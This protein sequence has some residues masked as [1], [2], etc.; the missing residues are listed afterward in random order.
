[1]IAEFGEQLAW[2]SAAVSRHY[3]GPIAYRTPVIFRQSIHETVLCE[4]MIGFDIT[5]REEV[6]DSLTLEEVRWTK[7]LD[8]RFVV[9]SGFPILSRLTSPTGIEVSWGVLQEYVG[10]Y[11]LTI[12]DGRVF[13][14][15]TCKT[16]V[17]VSGHE[18]VHLW[19]NIT[20]G[21]KHCCLST[22]RLNIWEL[23][24]DLLALQQGRHILDPDDAAI[25][26]GKSATSGFDDDFHSSDSYTDLCLHQKDVGSTPDSSERVPQTLRTEDHSGTLRRVSNTPTMGN[27]DL[28]SFIDLTAEEGTPTEPSSHIDIADITNRSE[29]S[30]ESDFLSMSELSDETSIP[31][32]SE[33]DPIFDVVKGVAL[34]L[35]SLHSFQTRGKTTGGGDGFTSVTLT[36]TPGQAPLATGGQLPAKGKRKAEEE[37]ESEQ[38]RKRTRAGKKQESTLACPFWKLDTLK[39]H[40]CARR[41]LTRVRDVKQHLNRNHTPKHYCQRCLRLFEND[42]ALRQHVSD[43]RGWSCPLATPDSLNGISHEQS[44]KLHRKSTSSQSDERQWFA[45]WEILFP[46]KARPR[47]AYMDPEL[48]EDLQAFQEHLDSRAGPVLH[49]ALESAGLL[50]GITTEEETILVQ[51]VISQALFGMQRE[52]LSSRTLISQAPNSASSFAQTPSNIHAE[53]PAA[54][55]ADS[56]IALGQHNSFN[57]QPPG[58]H[59]PL[60]LIEETSTDQ[61]SSVVSMPQALTAPLLHVFTEP[62]PSS[63]SNLTTG[64]FYWSQADGSY[65]EGLALNNFASTAHV[66]MNFAPVVHVDVPCFDVGGT[67]TQIDVPGIS[68]NQEEPQLSRTLTSS[69]P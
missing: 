30:I 60:P 41:K 13:L 2:L 48:S 58:L 51:R 24:A 21:R 10:E 3:D 8:R 29:T 17:L 23:W 18:D 40:N 47:S 66:N 64:P 45:I 50:Q 53:T 59:G 34:S 25:D 16:I 27:D 14:E 31:P 57:V 68:R 35:L 61:P 52:W 39:H 33:N 56:G 4:D 1:M 12:R 26:S 37:F 38:D 22:E 63:L 69:P 6:K 11:N 36:T 28:R 42:D 7:V 15:G 67:E 19:K 46:R 65:M 62:I 43:E 32:L 55:L 5:V 9:M 44:R 54:S 20:N 49:E